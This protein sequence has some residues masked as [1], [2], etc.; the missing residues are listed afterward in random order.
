LGE[1][2]D[3]AIEF[4]RDGVLVRASGELRREG[5]S[6]ELTNVTSLELLSSQEITPLQ[7]PVDQTEDASDGHSGLEPGPHNEPPF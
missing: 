6:W 7:L 1:T 4:H 3:D 5:R 2:Y